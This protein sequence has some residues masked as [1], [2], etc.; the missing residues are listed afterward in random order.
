MKLHDSV[1]HIH[2]INRFNTL[3]SDF[4]A[5]HGDRYS[6]DKVV[7]VNSRTKVI[8]T[9]PKHGDFTQIPSSHLNGKGCN[10]CTLEKTKYSTYVN[11]PTKLYFVKVTNLDNQTYFKIGVT[12][13]RVELRYYK[14]ISKGYKIVT[15]IEYEFKNGF[16]AYLL[17]QKLIRENKHLRPK[18]REP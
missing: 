12:L 10:S 3:E 4:R 17:E 18:L 13:S 2:T 16:I 1:T 9:C 5:V 14:E 11:R 7:Y 6:Y 8:I 15:L